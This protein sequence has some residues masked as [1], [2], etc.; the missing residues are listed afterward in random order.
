MREQA[1]LSAAEITTDRVNDFIADSEEES[2][3]EE[4]SHISRWSKPL[5]EKILRNVVDFSSPGRSCEDALMAKNGSI[6]VPKVNGKHNKHM[7]QVS[8]KANGDLLSLGNGAA[9]M[10]PAN[11][12]PHKEV[13]PGLESWQASKIASWHNLEGHSIQWFSVVCIDRRG[14]SFGNSDD[15]YFKLAFHRRFSIISGVLMLVAYKYKQLEEVGSDRICG[16]W[17]D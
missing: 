13:L 11:I 16:N 8:L 2:E 10:I 17:E 14:K 6:W 12:P 15:D 4:P 5:W 1:A 9:N 3:L 7:Q